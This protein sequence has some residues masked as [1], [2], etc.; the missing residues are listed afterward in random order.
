MRTLIL[1]LIALMLGAGLAIGQDADEQATAGRQY[2]I[3]ASRNAIV[4]AGHHLEADVLMRMVRGD[5]LNLV[6][7]E[8]TERYYHVFL[9]DGAW[10]GCPA[11]WCACSTVRRPT[12]R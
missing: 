9:P 10:A 3:E 7:N 4:R 5:C 1:C 12:K 11:T 6:T 8:Q 2:H